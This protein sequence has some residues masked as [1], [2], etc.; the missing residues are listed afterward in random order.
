[1]SKTHTTTYSPTTVRTL[2][3]KS[4]VPVEFSNR[5]HLGVV[6]S[7]VTS[8]NCVFSVVSIFIPA[9]R[10]LSSP[11][12]S[13]RPLVAAPQQL[14][15]HR[16]EA[17]SFILRDAASFAHPS[18][19][20]IPKCANLISNCICSGSTCHESCMQP[21][22]PQMTTL[23]HAGPVLSETPGWSCSREQMPLSVARLPFL[24]SS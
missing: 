21:P 17:A 11:T 10:W 7:D 13:A 12:N 4:R 14:Y 8:S 19:T 6:S 9:S 1:M 2:S 15:R 3:K 18:Q 20:R 24:T 23:P 5:H 16:C 22:L